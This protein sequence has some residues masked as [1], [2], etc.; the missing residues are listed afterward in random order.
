MT[1]LETL[2]ITLATGVTA[3][4]VAAIT[5]LLVEGRKHGYEDRIR[6]IDLRRDR[7]SELLREADQHVRILRRQHGVVEDWLTLGSTKNESPPPLDSTDPIGHLAAEI[8]LLGRKAEVGEAARAVY[9]ALVILD[10]Y[11]W[12]SDIGDAGAWLHNIDKGTR[13]A[14]AAYEEARTRFVAAARDDLGRR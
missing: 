14:L 7:Y 12:D 5:T 1:P 8:G 13:A 11:A 4:I 2:G 6:F 10:R 9:D 3:A